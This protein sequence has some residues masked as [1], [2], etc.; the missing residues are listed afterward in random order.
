M[1]EKVKMNINNLKCHV[2]ILKA[3][4]TF[5]DLKF[6]SDAKL[7]HWQNW[8]IGKTGAVFCF[9]TLMYALRSMNLRTPLNLPVP[10]APT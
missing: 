10:I 9:E 3:K 6:V 1:Q 7:V 8:Y 2:R 5:E 4:L